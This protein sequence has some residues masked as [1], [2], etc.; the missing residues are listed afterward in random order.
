MKKLKILYASHNSRINQKDIKCSNNNEIKDVS[1][2][3]NFKIFDT[4]FVYGID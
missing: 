2:V 1:F 4:S 3:K